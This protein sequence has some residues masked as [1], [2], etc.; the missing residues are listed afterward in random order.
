MKFGFIGGTPRG[1][2]LFTELVSLNYIPSFC[3]ILKEDDHET[4]KV[5]Y[6]LKTLTK[7]YNL[8]SEIKKKLS[9]KDSE[10][11]KELKLDFIIICGWRTLIDNKI[12][13]YLKF[14]L[15]AAH[16]SLLP[17]YRGFAPINWSIINGE[18]KSGVTLFYINSGEV[19]SGD[20]IL[21]KE[22]DIS[23]EDYAIDVYM[24]VIQATIDCFLSVFDIIDKM[25][26]LPRMTQDESLATYTCKR[27]PEDG[28]INWNLDSY[29]IYNLIRA[30][31]PPYPGAFCEFDC[32]KYIIR[33]AKIGNKKK[34]SGIIAGRVISIHPE[35]IEVLCLMGSILIMEWENFETGE[36][37][38]PSMHVKSITTTLK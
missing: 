30:I 18:K 5:S 37:S 25:H 33:K 20:I 9:I 22:V 14:G 17:K 28:K 16:D 3:V 6:E 10:K 26:E 27:M 35:Y 2:S 1:L 34:Y 19:D 32:K 15:I 11:I 8:D 31:A 38:C 24:K 36:I 12:N 21:Q 29:S 7:Q 4:I 13:N 23:P